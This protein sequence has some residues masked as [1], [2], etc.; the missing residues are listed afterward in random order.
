MP[1]TLLFCFS[2][3]VPSSS[4]SLLTSQQNN[5]IVLTW[6]EI[7]LV[8]RRGFL[9]GYNIYISNGSQLTLLGKCYDVKCNLYRQYSG[10]RGVL[11]VGM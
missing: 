1:P 10:Y 8:K 9:L 6:G 7:P 2:S 4:V 11:E 5:D 3:T